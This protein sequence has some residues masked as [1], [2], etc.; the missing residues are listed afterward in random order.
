MGKVYP[1]QE[2]TTSSKSHDH[3]LISRSNKRERY[4]VWMKS[5]VLHSNGCTVY[6][7]KGNIVYR[8]DNYDKKGKREVNLMD[9]QGNLLCTIKKTLLAFGCWE[10]YKYCNNSSLKSQEEQPWFKVKRCHKVFSGKI[11]CQIKVGCQNL[12]IER[13]S[14]GK[15]FA[16]RIINKDGEI[17]AEAKQKLSSSGVVLSNDILTL[18]LAAGTDHS[19][20]M[21]LITVYG[22]ICGKM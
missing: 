17:I 9:Q 5:L 14:I 11:A 16:F 12:C 8:V 20:I 7:S 18:D 13:I 19:L 1:H 10:G 22:L 15:S 4:T 21:A 6:D 2:S 3:C